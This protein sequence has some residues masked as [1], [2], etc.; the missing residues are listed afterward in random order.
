MLP[1][2][3]QSEGED[4]APPSSYRRGKVVGVDHIPELVAWSRANLLAALPQA[5]SWLSSGDVELVCGDGRTGWPSA[6]P[7]D[8][9]HVGA[10]APHLPRNLISQL[11][12]RGRMICPVGPVG[13]LQSLMQVDKDASGVTTIKDIIGVQVRVCVHW[14]VGWKA[15]ACALAASRS[16][17]P[18]LR[19]C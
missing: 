19:A 5:A 10:A 8:V 2:T 15:L 7:F 4:S 17:A 12:P 14:E 16:C 3:V 11:A 9:I 1:S 13:G 18:P 6:A